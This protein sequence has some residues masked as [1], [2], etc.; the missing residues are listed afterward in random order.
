MLEAKM[1]IEMFDML[2][3]ETQNELS[4]I[5][6]LVSR[7]Q[8]KFYTQL[9]NYFLRSELHNLEIETR[10]ELTTKKTNG[11]HEPDSFL[12]WPI[13]SHCGREI[14][15]LCMS[16]AVNCYMYDEGSYMEMVSMLYNTCRVIAYG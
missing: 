4:T 9:H 10:K 5:M 3:E 12:C 13:D 2:I 1:V 15:F 8:C 6:P 7:A 16:Q 14:L 11:R